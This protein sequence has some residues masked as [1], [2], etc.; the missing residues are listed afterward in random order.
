MFARFTILAKPVK[1]LAVSAI[2]R[3]R[4]HLNFLLKPTRKRGYRCKETTRDQ[5]F[6]IFLFFALLVRFTHT[7]PSLF[8]QICLAV[9]L[10]SI[11]MQQTKNL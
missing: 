2:C 4:E 1:R 8:S 9:F 3:S 5:K 11:L 10:L 7:G 6:K